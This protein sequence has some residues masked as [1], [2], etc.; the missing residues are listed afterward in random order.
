MNEEALSHTRRLNNRKEME[1]DFRRL[2]ASR[3]T[4]IGLLSGGCLV[5]NWIYRL[6]VYD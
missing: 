4:A 5:W 2:Q 1:R 3:V 6:I